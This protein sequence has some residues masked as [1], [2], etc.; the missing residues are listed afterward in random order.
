MSLKEFIEKEL[1]KR[2][3]QEPQFALKLQNK[4][5]SIDQC[6]KYIYGEVL[7]RFI[8][9]KSG[10]QAAAVERDELVNMAVHYYDED[11]IK[12]RPLTGVGA[13][14]T[15]G[16]D[17]SASKPRAKAKDKETVKK[18]AKVSENASKREK[19]RRPKDTAKV[20]KKPTVEDMFF[21]TLFDESFFED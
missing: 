7:H 9:S 16:S 11:N 20:S 10:V 3:E 15:A 1:Q 17:R 12:I 6:I 19:T 13:V 18:V 21:G 2:C 5:K 14:R 4:S 8:S